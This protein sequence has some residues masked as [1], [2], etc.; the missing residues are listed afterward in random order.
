M[1][2]MNIH[3]GTKSDSTMGKDN[4]S[5]KLDQR[6][7]ETIRDVCSSGQKCAQLERDVEISRFIEALEKLV[8][9]R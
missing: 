2:M 5:A 8:E 6:D 4:C 1:T 7:P 9:K 3:D